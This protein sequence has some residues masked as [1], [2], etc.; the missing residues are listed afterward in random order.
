[1]TFRWTAGVRR[2]VLPNGLTLL[3]QRDP[4][5]PVVAVVS[6]I[7][8]GFFDE[9]DH[10]VGV[11]H[12]LEHMLFKGTPTRGVGEIARETKAAGGYLNAATGYDRTT[13]FSVLPPAS[14]PIAL[15]LQSDALRRSLIDREELRRELKV[16][17][18]EAK[19]KLDTPAAVAAET[20]NALLFDVHRIRRWRIGTEPHLAALPHE[21]VVSYYRSR[22]VPGRT[23]VAMAGDLDP[24]SALAM[25]RDLFAGWPAAE[26]V[27]DPSP[28]EPPH[29]GVRTRVLRGDVKRAELVLGWRA[30]PALHP[31]APALELAGAVLGSGRAGWLYRALRASGIVNTVGAGLYA[32]SEVGVFSIGAELAPERLPEALD[33][34]G[35]AVARLRDH[36][37]SDGDLDRVRTLLRARWARGLE[38]AEGRATALA[39]A[40]AMGGYRILDDEF[41][42]LMAVRAADVQRVALAWLDPGMVAAVAY[43][44]DGAPDHLDPAGLEARFRTAPAPAE[45]QP[46]APP[47]RSPLRVR[48][49]TT[50]GVLHIALPGADLLLGRKPG[51]PL[52]SLGMYRRRTMTEARATAGLASLAVRAATRGAGPYDAA[53]LALAFERLGGTVAP[54]I[55]ADWFGVGATVL[56]DGAGDAASLLH[57]V[58]T[59]PRFDP[60]EIELER[61]TLGGEA[62]RAADDMVRYPV[63]LALLAAFG[64]QG[65]GLPVIGLPDSISG[66]T[67]GMVKA[68][69]ACELAEGRTTIVAVGDLDPERLADHLAGIL[70]GAPPRTR[71][72]ADPVAGWTAERRS[73]VV[74]RAKKQTAL[75]VLYPGP[76]RTSPDRHAAEV[77]SAIAS[78][79]GGRLFTALRDQRS[80]AYTVTAS[81]WQRASAGAL[82]LYLA[83][84]PEREDEA[85]EA[86]LAELAGFRDSEPRADE[87]ARGVKYLSGQIQVRRQTAAAVAGEVAEAW[88]L[89][90]GLREVAEP[91]AG[92]ASVS[93]RVIRDLMAVLLDPAGRVEGIVRGTADDRT[94]YVS[95]SPIL[96]RV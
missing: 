30:V 73:L 90:E 95:G 2:D 32:P 75:A 64:E 83:T 22:Y 40:E 71:V 15:D 36:G 70:A 76:A 92:I 79:L 88:L 61:L 58:L 96:E 14:L 67:H 3:A 68:W 69:H 16:I 72:P 85:R 19:R 6:H 28:E 53:E 5:A 8:A 27:L 13:Y 54:M 82:L 33:G 57:L 50:S 29:R 11:S 80:F 31:D 55:A 84:S 49:V 45:Q 17:I 78:G 94:E 21:D 89:G 52:V 48:G 77:W 23:I 51:V 7:R 10:Q 1:M 12:V 37:P 60:A 20:L 24:E 44:P 41:D 25:A 59:E 35:S 91:A 18:E 65:Y 4:S 63:Q 47:A 81:S 42:R 86:L 56:S 93:A 38:S 9:P 62:A 34:I 26:A 46:P 66:L 87:L 43:L 74:G 39:S